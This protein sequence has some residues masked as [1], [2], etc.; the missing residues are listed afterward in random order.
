MCCGSGR[1]LGEEPRWC[2]R[3]DDESF[4]DGCRRKNAERLQDAPA[5]CRRRE[6][7]HLGVV[8][9][10]HAARKQTKILLFVDQFE[11]LYTQVSDPQER[12]AYTA[13]LA[14]AAD[15][16]TAPVR[17]VVS[18]RSDFL[19]RAGEDRRFL[20]ELTRGLVFLQPLGPTALRD[21]LVQPLEARAYQFET[22]EMV[23]EMLAA[24]ESA[25]GALPLLQFAASKLWETRDRG[26]KLLA[27]ASYDAMGGIS[28]ALATHADQVLSTLAPPAQH[29]AR[30]V[31]L[32]LVTPERTRA[33]VD[34]RE[35][36]ELATDP[37]AIEAVVDHL[38][39]A[40]LLV[41]Q[42][43]SESAG[44]SVEIVHE[45]LTSSWPTL[46]R[47]LD[48][49]QDDATQLAQ[50]RTAAAQ[51]DSKGRTQGLLWRGEAMAEAKRWHA[52]YRG[53]LPTRERMFLAAVFALGTRAARVK[54]TIVIGVIAVLSIAVIGSAVALIAIGNAER[55]AKAEEQRAEDQ[56]SRAQIEADHAKQAERVAQERLDQ[57]KTEQAA[58]QKAEDVAR[59]KGAEVEMTQGELKIA[60]AKAE[61]ERALAVEQAT[62]ARSAAAAEKTAKDA[63]NRLYLVEKAR[64]EA[65]EKQR[66]KI[67]TELP[68]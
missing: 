48:E 8:L 31:F 25:P 30:A 4:I 60:L 17:I 29:H 67:T 23:D 64:R 9:R 21:A 55:T 44:A 24:L 27:R 63:A 1:H 65:A 47:W 52:R 56:R 22:R 50:L 37:R 28:G 26:R 40:R 36:H 3:R 12:L 20:D 68:K 45:S 5:S 46:R 33:V 7:G 35:L 41:V 61:Q 66:A 10:E 34:I 42:S 2:H 14:A 38:V 54:R 19:D 13:C 53:E 62:K 18:M 43:S 16:A 39:A 15:D 11:E 6:P 32:R 57:L 59:A 49:G 58:K 51:W